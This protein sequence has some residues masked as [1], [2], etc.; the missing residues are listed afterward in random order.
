[1]DVS[2]ACIINTKHII[3]EG[4]AWLLNN[5]SLYCN[6]R[7]ISLSFLDSDVEG[8]AVGTPLSVHVILHDVV[9]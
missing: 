4:E 8:S 6:F 3:L 5:L 9:V 7:L 1:M 2:T